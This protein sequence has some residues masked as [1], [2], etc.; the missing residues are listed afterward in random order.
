MTT[1][2]TRQRLRAALVGWKNGN[3]R[4][5]RNTRQPSL[6]DRRTLLK[7][8][9]VGLALPWLEAMGSPQ[10]AAGQA[11]A[12]DGSVA[13]KRMLAICNNLGVLPDQFFP[14]ENGRDYRLSPYLRQLESFR[15]K[16][17]VFSGVSHPGVDGSH[18]SDVSFLTAAPHPGSG[19]FRNSISLDQFIANQLGHLTRYPSLTLGVNAKQGRRSLSWTDGGVLIPCQDSAA[20]V[21]RQLF[22]QGSTAEVD[23]QIR[24]LELGQSI[25]DMLSE[26][27]RSLGRQLGAADR[28]R[29]DQYTT[30]V[31][32]VERRMQESQQWKRTPKPQTDVELPVD[33]LEKSGYIEKT[34]LMYQMAKLAFETDS[35]RSVSLLLDSNNSPTISVNGA[36]ITDGYHNLSHHGRSEKKLKQLQA[37]DN[38]HMKLLAELIGDLKQ[39]EEP[40]GELLENT[41]VLYGSNFG[42]ANKHTTDNMPIL[43]AGG[44][45]RHGQHLAFDREQNYPLPNLYVSMLQQ[46]GIETDSF[47]SATGTMRGMTS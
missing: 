24:R 45:F 37:I 7:G 32:D 4:A 44:G 6:L 29:M 41:M 16:F 3:K 19:G 30:A 8:S 9:G 2:K 11:G 18:S 39:I 31:R 15:D 43:L 47:A 34:R 22:L 40:H 26:Q 14:D 23:R 35:T 5:L 13:P 17:T 33:P 46:M 20:A 36:D 42:D 38:A 1:T 27:A 21:Y 12:G 25:M 10:A 28:N